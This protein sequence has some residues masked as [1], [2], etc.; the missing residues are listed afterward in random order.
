VVVYCYTYA[1]VQTNQIENNNFYF[2][3]SGSLFPETNTKNYVIPVEFFANIPVTC[4]A[5]S[6]A[7]VLVG[8]RKKR[9]HLITIGYD[10]L[11]CVGDNKYGQTGKDAEFKY[12]NFTCNGLEKENITH[13][14]C[15]GHFSCAVVDRKDV[16]M[17]GSNID[18]QLGLGT[19]EKIIYTPMKCPDFLGNQRVKSLHCMTN[20]SILIT[21]T[22]HDAA[23]NNYRS[24]QSILCW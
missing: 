23:L 19:I 1:I 22:H 5:A 11:Y 3:G 15:G 20:R 14:G 2:Q 21:G 16:W 24:F 6:S 18:Q 7:H 4:V 13:V 9:T 10:G 17:F 8:T 12:A